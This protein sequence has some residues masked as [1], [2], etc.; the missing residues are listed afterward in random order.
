APSTKDYNLPGLFIEN[1]LAQE[2]MGHR[3]VS[4]QDILQSVASIDIIVFHHV[5]E[6]N[7]KSLLKNIKRNIKQRL[8]QLLEKNISISI[9]LED[10]AVSNTTDSMEDIAKALKNPLKVD[11]VKVDLENSEVP[12]MISDLMT[13]LSKNSLIV[14][15]L[16]IMLFIGVLIWCMLKLTKAIRDKKIEIPAGNGTTAPA[17]IR[18][19]EP[20]KKQRTVSND[21]NVFESYIDVL[22]ILKTTITENSQIV[23]KLIDVAATIKD[24]ELIIVILDVIEKDQKSVFYNSLPINIRK[25][26]KDY[27]VSKAIKT[28]QDEERLKE[29]AI[30]VIKLIKVASLDETEFYR[31]ML[32]DFCQSIADTDLTPVFLECTAKEVSYLINII[33]PVQ[34]SY[35]ISKGTI[36]PN[37]I[38]NKSYEQLNKSEL[39]DLIVK[40]SS[41]LD[42]FTK[43]SNDNKLQQIFAH[44]H[45]NDEGQAAQEMGIDTKFTLDSLFSQYESQAIN[46]LNRMNFQDISQIYA[47]LSQPIIDKL[48]TSLPELLRE[49]LLNIK[50]DITNNGVKL[51]G[52]LY[53]YLYTLE[54]ENDHEKKDSDQNEDAR[55]VD[56]D[57]IAA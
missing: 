53:N 57:D 36:K 18:Q 41:H 12:K 35:A 9:M 23:I 11:K 8:P 3:E 42:T 34:I 24:F 13:K 16:L 27:V 10:A 55:H 14:I 46:Y 32:N 15:G 52:E 54:I 51:K 21:T 2:L 49:R 30:K 7:E 44:L 20:E 22:S 28:Y 37:V 56:D 29:R 48:M 50:I 31:I 6:L 19:T 1:K 45:T 5:K 43:Q 47:L 17:V 26:F 33:D 38:F 39:M 40:I 25:A 4:D